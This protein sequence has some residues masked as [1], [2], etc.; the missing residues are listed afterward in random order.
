VVIQLTG[1]V[2]AAPFYIA[3]T[4]FY[5]PVPVTPETIAAMLWVGVAVTVLAV[6]LTNTAVRII[7]A[8]KASMG[9][10]LRA[11]FTAILAILVLGE[12]FQTFHAVGLVLVIGGV[13]LM[14]RSH[15]RKA[16]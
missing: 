3:E 5:R 9:N 13:F 16:A 8:N 2:V 12:Q 7:G 15:R 4:I 10:Y 14:T 6:G 11:G 1:L